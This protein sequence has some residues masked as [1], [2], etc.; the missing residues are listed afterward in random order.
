MGLA[1]LGMWALRF[2]NPGALPR[3][4]EIGISLQ[5]LGF[6]ALVTVG[7][8]LLFGLVPALQAGGGFEA[9]RRATGSR[10]AGDRI[11]RRVRGVLVTSEVALS[12]VVV[13]CA[14][15][16]ARSFGELMRVDTGMETEGRL[17]FG[18][19]FPPNDYP[20]NE[21]RV[22]FVESLL[23]RIEA[24]P[25]VSGAEFT[26][27][28][29]LSG[30]LWFEDPRVQGRAAAPEG[31]SPLIGIAYAVSPGYLESM[32]IE[33]ARGRGF[34]EWDG[35][36][37]APVALVSQEAA[38]AFWPD[39]DP[40]GSMIGLQGQEEAGRP[41]IRVVG[42]VEDT[43]PQ[44]LQVEPRPQFYFLHTQSPVALGFARRSG[45]VVVRSMED[46]LALVPPLRR[47]VAE[48]DQNMPLTNLRT[49]DDLVSFVTAGPR[50]TSSFL[51][52]SGLLALVLA[53][54]GVYG[55]VSHSVAKRTREIGVRVALGA[56]KEQVIRLMVREGVRPALLGV[57]LGVL[58]ALFATDLLEGMLFQVSATDPLTFI[59]LPLLLLS[60]A[61][62]ASWIPARRSSRVAPVE[63]LREE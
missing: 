59:S 46:P 63:A 4:D 49:M 31:E 10:T 53:L 32:G 57:G 24:I 7:A 1:A 5:V 35:A 13:V 2:I 60:V 34:R 33:V 18:V 54:V 14:G 62:L 30:N 25:G 8:A 27:N 12:V 19:G 58:G 40:L 48:L 55:V 37:S 52:T 39:E 45:T 20:T 26:T 17:T 41:W 28:L 51:G 15:L 42:V 61:A 38:R 9:G 29:P 16:V 47:G 21:G 44:G 36:E 56:R 23:E 3:M 6:T 11:S 50:L 22:A 43:R